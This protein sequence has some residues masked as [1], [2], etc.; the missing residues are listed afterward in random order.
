MGRLSIRTAGVVAADLLLLALCLLHIPALLNRA[1]IPFLVD[2][3][4]ATPHVYAVVS[5]AESAGIREGDGIVLVDGLPVS[6]PEVLEFIG[7]RHRIGEK[8][9]VVARQGDA[10]VTHPV[11]LI[12]Y[13]SVDQIVVFFVIGILTWLVGLYVLL[14]GPPGATTH[15]LHGAMIAMA[16]VVMVAWEGVTPAG[17][18]PP[19]VASAL[20]FASYYLVAAQFVHFTRRFPAVVAGGTDMTAI[21]VYLTGP[22][23]IVPMMVFYVRAFLDRSAADF[24]RYCDWFDAF[25]LVVLALILWGLARFVLAYV[26]SRSA[27]IRQKLR[28]ILVGFLFGPTPFF[29]LTVLPGLVAPHLAL[30]EHVT[31]ASL[32]IIPIAFAVSFVRYALL[33][34]SFVVKRTTVYGIALV[35]VLAVYLGIVAGASYVVGQYV[36]E[37][38]MVAAVLVALL[39]DPVRRRVQGLVDRRFFRVRYDYRT[40]ERRFVD[41]ITR[42]IDEKQLGD[43]IVRE[44]ADLIPVHAIGFFVLQRGTNRL[45][46][47]AHRNFPMLERRG[48]TF[49]PDKLQTGLERPVARVECIEPGVMHEAADGEV[50]RRW[51]MAVVFPMRSESGAFLGFLV[52]GEKLSGVRF[53]AED[54]DLLN[55]VAAHAGLEIERIVLQ[56]DLMAK[57]AEARHLDELNRLK[58]EFVEYVSHEFITP[59]TA[60]KNYSEL[61][62]SPARGLDRKGQK[63]AA[64]IDGESERLTRMV[65]TLLDT[66]RIDQGIKEYT[67][68][69]M[70]LR[71]AAR[72]AVEAMTYQLKK[73]KFRFELRVGRGDMTISGD[74]DAVGQAIR[75]LLSN[76]IK[77]A[78]DTK[79]I[80]VRLSRHNDIRCCT[81]E[82]R[83]PGISKEALPHIFERFYRDPDR[84][85]AVQGVGL[86]LALV[87]HIMDAHGGD[88]QIRS[89]PGV[90]TTVSLRFRVEGPGHETTSPPSDR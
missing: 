25:H 44:T 23:V 42:C 26:R 17:V 81:V 67:F 65:R 40:A 62:R 63:F 51:G 49:E 78:G 30:P 79:F 73:K 13:Y 14:K 39:F 59:L 76:S 2:T 48:V 90:G 75:N 56:R 18:L 37:S 8:V 85:R 3:R 28:W 16:V 50:F 20:F 71:S 5:D 7:D 64:V 34:I 80:S 84:D 55:V 38:A 36:R 21:L 29:F 9:D 57:E 41:R 43:L 82:D 27:D 87:K 1:K 47:V 66:A 54:V 60:I 35:G 88:V 12:R 86:G 31:L 61:L 53:T 70:D 6:R 58:T 69:P 22:V 89:T 19:Y 77:Y 4:T 32:I 46:C 52:M 72:E 74:P 10:Q 24:L 83:G 45:R 33:D 68:R 11:T 15:I